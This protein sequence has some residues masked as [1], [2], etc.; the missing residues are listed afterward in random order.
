MPKTKFRVHF[1]IIFK[2]VDSFLGQHPALLFGLSA[3]IGFYASQGFSY[4]LCLAVFFIFFPLFLK[5]HL[6]R[7]RLTLAF[8]LLTT[9]FLYGNVVYR[10]PQLP[11][12]GVEGILYFDITSLSLNQT[13]FGYQWVYRGNG[14][15]FIPISNNF[16]LA[17]GKNFPCSLSFPKNAR[18][19][20]P[21]GD[22][23]YLISGRLKETARGGFHFYVNKEVPWQSVKGSWSFAEIRY[24]IKAW[25]KNW[26][27]SRIADS[28]SAEFIGGIITGE[29]EDKIMRNEFGKLG[30]LHIMAISGFHFS[31]IAIMIQAMLRLFLPLRIAIGVLIFSLSFY[32]FI[33]GW[34]AS[35]VR[36]WVMTLIAILSFYIEK[37]SLAL[38]SLGVSILA[39]FLIDPHL[40]LSIGFQ[41]SAITTAAIL[42]WYPL[43]DELLKSIWAKRQLGQL[44]KM[45]QVDQHSY[46]LVST[47][48]QALALAIAVNIVAVPSTLFFFK[49]FPLMSFF[50][51]LFIPFL[52]SISMFLFLLG[53]FLDLIHPQLGSLLHAINSYSTHFMLSSIYNLPPS[54]SCFWRVAPFSSLYLVFFLYIIFGIGVM[55]RTYSLLE[56]KESGILTNTQPF[57]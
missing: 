28:Q 48:R 23:A 1:D 9:F 3:L 17:Q 12:E 42:I 6:L 4:S 31:I 32:F 46:F 15:K 56:R 24:Q 43:A 25:V 20:R 35:I 55:L 13:H 21:K 44:I 57:R 37:P 39:I 47:F 51:N 54:L 33:L 34:G 45:N 22:H 52:V 11:T 29:F 53:A 49:K 27:T 40:L 41:F 19:V 38:N 16:K 5:Y 36:A 30:L 2:V 14:Q 10:N 18:I 26:I 8:L 7:Q 50:Y